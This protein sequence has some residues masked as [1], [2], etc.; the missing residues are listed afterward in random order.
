MGSLNCLWRYYQAGLLNTLFGYGAYAILIKLGLWMYA[1]Q[2]IA[3]GLGVLFNYLTYSRHAFADRDASKSRFVVAYVF[4]YLFLLI[5]L[6]AAAQL[7]SSPYLAGLV[8]IVVVSLINYL[9]LKSL[10]FT[11][12]ARA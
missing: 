11:R 10:V 12:I 6:F 4:N 1:A 2:L 9:V 7:I 3:H 5:S 8:S